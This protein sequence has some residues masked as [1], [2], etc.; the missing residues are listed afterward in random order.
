MI[1]E[2]FTHLLTPAPKWV[3]KLGF[4]AEAIAIDARYKRCQKNWQP[5]LIASKKAILAEVKK[6]PKGAN[7]LVLGAGG[8]HD[9]PYRCLA[10]DGY[11]LSLVDIIF[12]NAARKKL[13]GLSGISLIE[14]DI[15]NYGEEF[16]HWL[17]NTNE[18]CPKPISPPQINELISEK[19]DLII[20][21]NILSQLPIQ[22]EEKANKIQPELDFTERELALMEQHINWLK[23]QPCPVLLIGDMERQTIEDGKVKEIEL[24]P[25]IEG[26]GKPI[27]TWQWDI[28]PQGEAHRTRSLRHKVGAWLFNS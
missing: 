1:V 4:V 7:I 11:K 6:L 9:V 18:T 24:I 15:T 28:A 13:R 23:K 2:F 19:P 3:K 12:L 21:L 25:L 10:V 26:L 22:F 8:L 5:H 16:A 17:E 20:S 14:R 27:N